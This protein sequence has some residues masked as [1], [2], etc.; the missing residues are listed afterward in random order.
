MQFSINWRAKLYVSFYFLFVEICNW[1]KGRHVNFFETSRQK[2]L[3][4]CK[5]NRSKIKQLR[6]DLAVFSC[7]LW[8]VRH[9]FFLPLQF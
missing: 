3:G 6:P 8:L 5:P 7:S 2:T 4:F 1:L 9:F